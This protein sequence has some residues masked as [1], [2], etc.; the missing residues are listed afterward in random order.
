MPVDIVVSRVSVKMLT[1][2]P[3]WHEALVEVLV[4]GAGAAGIAAARTLHDAGVAVTVLEARP[5]LGGRVVTDQSLAPHPVELGAEFIHG[6]RALTWKYVDQFGFTALPDANHGFCFLHGHLYHDQQAPLP[7]CEELLTVLKARAREHL[8]AHGPDISVA[9]FLA[10]QKGYPLHPSFAA[11]ARLLSNLIASEKGAD[12][13]PMS[14]SGLLEH[15]FSGYG[16][17]NFRLGEGYAALLKRLAR[18]LD[19]RPRHP[20]HRVAW[21]A[22]GARISCPGRSF[23][24]RHVVV[25]LPLG[26]LQKGAVVFSPPLPAAKRRAVAGL[27]AAP[28][29][30]M[31][32]QFRQSFWSDYLAVLTTTG[33]TQVWWPS[34]WGRPDPGPVLTALIG[35][36]AARRFASLG[37]RALPEALRQLEVMFGRD[38]RDL[39]VGGRIVRWHRQRYSRMGCPYSP[40]VCPARRGV[41]PPGPLP[42]PLSFAGEPTTRQQ[43]STVHGPRESGARA[44][45]QVLEARERVGPAPPAGPR[46]HGGHAPT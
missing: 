37:D 45:Q 21:G 22:D 46:S 7:G 24:A 36:E 40:A 35:G 28:V 11:T 32:L 4:I 33:E 41:W 34:G 16:D 27:G 14:L 2:E 30:K 31:I 19:I 26:V 15:D 3:A 18:G 25:T 39:C 6:K 23:A 44:A 13:D 42:P 29:C 38:L 1:H 9:Q 10:G 12:A 17:N 43:P 8:S 20:V 5:R